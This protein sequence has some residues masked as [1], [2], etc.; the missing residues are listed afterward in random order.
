MKKLF[1]L[2]ILLLIYFPSYSQFTGGSG[3]GADKAQIRT[4]TILSVENEQEK[5]FFEQIKMTSQSNSFS[6]KWNDKVKLQQIEII[7]ILGR[8]Q[9]IVSISEFQKS[10]S[11]SFDGT[12]KAKGIYFVRFRDGEGRFFSKKIVF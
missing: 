6:I 1:A 2:L 10:I 11:I 7:D 4:R 3:G 12:N 8:I 9:K 5:A